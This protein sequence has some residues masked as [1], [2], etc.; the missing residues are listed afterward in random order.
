MVKQED[1]GDGTNADVRGQREFVLN[2]VRRE[3]QGVGSLITGPA[4]R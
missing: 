3:T 1:A 2:A 4:A